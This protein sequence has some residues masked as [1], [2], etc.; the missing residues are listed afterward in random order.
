VKK[1]DE[2]ELIRE[3]IKEYEAHDELI[4]RRVVREIVREL[5]M[6][7]KRAAYILY[8]LDGQQYY[9]YGISVMAGWLQNVKE[10]KEL[11]K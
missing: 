8:K 5:G 3:L 11:I 1:P 2:I 10:L 9:N 4:D 7:E 6:N